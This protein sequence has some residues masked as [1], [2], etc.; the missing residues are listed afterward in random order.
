VVCM[1]VWRGVIQQKK[2]KVDRRVRLGLEELRKSG[3]A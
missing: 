2:H 3:M 1:Y